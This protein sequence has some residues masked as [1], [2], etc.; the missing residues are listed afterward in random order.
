MVFGLVHQRILLDLKVHKVQPDHK[1]LQ[2][3]KALKDLLA[4]QDQPVLKA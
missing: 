2:V 4:Q 1:V 3:L